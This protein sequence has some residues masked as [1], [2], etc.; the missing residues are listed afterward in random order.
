M[1][2]KYFIVLLCVGFFASACG[3]KSPIL[4]TVG[5][6]SI[7]LKEFEEQLASL[8]SVYRSMVVTA[9]QK[10][11]LL[12][13]MITERLLIQEAIKEGLHRKKEIQK[14]LKLLKN[15]MLIEELIKSKIY[16]KIE[17]S[18]EEAKKFYNAHQQELTKYFKGKKFDEMKKEIKQLMRKD[19]TKARLMFKNWLEELKKEAKITKNLALLGVSEKEEGKK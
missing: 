3:S 2:S 18:D 5:G 6:E 12:D 16:D 1:K 19:D 4:A 8:P 7:T 10:E 11:K 15:Q 17:I 13:Q 14:N 9:E